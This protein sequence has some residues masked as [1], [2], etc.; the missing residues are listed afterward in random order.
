MIVTK[1]HFSEKT[2]GI[3]TIVKVSLLARIKH[4]VADSGLSAR[5]F[6]INAIVE[7]LDRE[8]AQRNEP[9]KKTNKPK[10]RKK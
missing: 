1:N 9:P 7:K 4:S 2:T 3:H 5:Q 8:Q 10:K 6:V